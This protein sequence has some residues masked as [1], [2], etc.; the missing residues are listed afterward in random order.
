M[1]EI[2]G[3]LLVNV[4]VS[5]PFF[6][7]KDTAICNFADDTTILTANSCLDKVL[8]RL[9]TDALVLSMWFLESFMKLI[10]GKCHLL[11]FGTIQSNIKINIRETIA[12]EGS[13]EKL[14]KV[15]LDKNLNCK[16]HISSLC[17]RASQRVQ[18][19]ARV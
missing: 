17:K 11:A 14:L 8:E 16:S 10:E 1:A 2:L 13:G 9:E 5:D 19:L 4:Y 15:I 18:T 3:P 12:E 7:V 6:M